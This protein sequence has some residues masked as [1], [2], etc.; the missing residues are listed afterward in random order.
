M[1]PNK[2]NLYLRDWQ[3]IDV[4]QWKNIQFTPADYA[5]QQTASVFVNDY[6]IVSLDSSPNRIDVV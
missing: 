5:A 1:E 2:S 6:L 3:K 4:F